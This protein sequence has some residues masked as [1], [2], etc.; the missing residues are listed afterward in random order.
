MKILRNKND[1][2]KINEIFGEIAQLKQQLESGPYGRGTLFRKA[3]EKTLTAV[4][5]VRY[6]PIREVLQGGGLVGTVE[7]GQD[8]VL[9]VILIGDGFSDK[10]LPILKRLKNLGLLRLIDTKLTDTGIGELLQT[11]PALT[12]EKAAFR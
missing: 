1:E 6:Q 5:A 12:I 4:Q 7:R 2:K 10:I 8:V 11:L 9:T 3:V